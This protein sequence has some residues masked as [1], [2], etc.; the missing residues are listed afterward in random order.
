[1]D[2]HGGSKLIHG[3]SI[4]REELLNLGPSSGASLEDVGSPL[5]GAGRP[6]VLPRAGDDPVAIH[7]HEQPES[8]EETRV[9]P[10]Q[11]RALSPRGAD[12]VEYIDGAPTAGP[13]RADDQAIRGH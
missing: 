6:I 2:R 11:L 7:P 10:G 8:I 1:M 3:S 9:A 13:R 5:V 12:S 4:T